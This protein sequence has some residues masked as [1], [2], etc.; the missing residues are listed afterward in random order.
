MSFE[1]ARVPA[2][3]PCRLCRR[4]LR[5]RR[6]HLDA[7]SALSFD[8][9][10]LHCS[11]EYSRRTPFGECVVFG[12][13]SVLVSLAE[14]AGSRPFRLRGLEAQFR[15]PLF[16]NREYVLEVCE[17]GDGVVASILAGGVLH[18]RIALAAALGENETTGVAEAVD[19]FIPLGSAAMFEFPTTS[20]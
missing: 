19:N 15:K 1:H 17:E 13:A 6:E 14:W 12:M 9:N 4:T 8:V 5:F 16:L 3:S 10:P 20:S 18:T 2:E 11:E 7:F